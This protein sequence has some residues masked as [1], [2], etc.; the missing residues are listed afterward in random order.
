MADSIVMTEARKVVVADGFLEALVLSVICGIERGLGY[1]LAGF[2][3]LSRIN[4]R[5]TQ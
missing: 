5:E 2:W 3:N 4:L 1:P